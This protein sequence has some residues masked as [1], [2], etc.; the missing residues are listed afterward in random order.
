MRL[1]GPDGMR[2]SRKRRHHVAPLCGRLPVS[3][4][5]RICQSIPTQSVLSELDSAF[6]DRPGRACWAHACVSF[7]RPLDLWLGGVGFR[8]HRVGHLVQRLQ[9]GLC[10]W[11]HLVTAPRDDSEWLHLRHPSAAAALQ[12][13]LLCSRAQR[14]LLAAQQPCRVFCSRLIITGM[15]VVSTRLR[16]RPRPR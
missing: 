15:E 3:A 8:I 14:S 4:D 6:L 9:H 1:V 2:A 16:G 5:G 10:A 7:W 11:R 12:A 13:V